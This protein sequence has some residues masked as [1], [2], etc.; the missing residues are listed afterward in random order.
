MNT[1]QVALLS[2]FDNSLDA[3]CA[4]THL[5]HGVKLGNRQNRNVNSKQTIAIT[6]SF[7]FFEAVCRIFVLAFAR[8]SHNSFDV[9]EKVVA[10]FNRGASGTRANPMLDRNTTEDV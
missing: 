7:R 8:T 1:P 9:L 2:R 3:H 5:P 6:S 4:V 10:T